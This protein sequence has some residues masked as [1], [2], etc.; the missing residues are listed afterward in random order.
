MK[1]M[2]YTIYLAVFVLVFASCARSGPVPLSDSEKA[3]I[4]K[5][6]ADVNRAFNETKDYKAYVRDYYAEDAMILYPNSEAIKGRE[7]ITAALS[8]FGADLNVTPTV[9]EVNGYNDLAYVYGTVKM[10]T[11]AGKEIDHGKYIEIWKKQKDGK[12]QVSRDIFNSSIPMVMDS[13][14]H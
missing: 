6:S 4:A 12:W 9:L 3:M 13:T 11:N 5:T 10:E 2:I 1:K 7:A 8:G 14:M